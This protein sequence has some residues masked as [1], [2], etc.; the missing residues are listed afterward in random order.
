M[1]YNLLFRK[2]S[3]NTLILNY[4]AKYVTMCLQR[5]TTVFGES[6]YPIT[7]YQI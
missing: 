6:F 2:T 4:L 3:N 1:K 7:T 5:I